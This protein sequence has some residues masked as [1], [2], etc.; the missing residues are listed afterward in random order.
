MR[1]HKFTPARTHACSPTRTLKHARACAPD[2]D[3]EIHLLDDSE[4]AFEFDR[5]TRFLDMEGG[6]PITADPTL[7]GKQYKTAMTGYLDDLQTVMRKAAVDYDRVSLQDP[8][9]EVLARFL[10]RRR[11]KKKGGA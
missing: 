3:F 1:A 9:A 10:V 8:V 6:E 7:M 2:A 4:I 11:P 5:P